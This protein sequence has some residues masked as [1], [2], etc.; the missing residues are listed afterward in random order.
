MKVRPAGVSIVAGAFIILGIYYFIWSLFLFGV[1]LFS[2][3]ESI[4]YQSLL[5]SDL[6]S[7]ILGMITTVIMV[8]TG[9]GLLGLKKWSWYLA[10]L[11]LVLMLIH[12]VFGLS[13]STALWALFQLALAAIFGYILLQKETREVFEIGS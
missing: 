4:F 8:A 2:G 12:I 7:A 10:F 1:S 3:S 6:M 11:A 5:G 9:I 13:D